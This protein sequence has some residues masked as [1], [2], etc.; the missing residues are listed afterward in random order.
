MSCDKP[1]IA[2]FARPQAVLFDIGMTII[3]PCGDILAHEIGLL[4]PG[5][6]VQGS[7]ALRALALAAE[8]H[9][10]DIGCVGSDSDRVGWVMGHLLGLTPELGIRAWRAASARPD[11]YSLLDPHAVPVLEAL[12]RAGIRT[13][14]VSNALNCIEDELEAFGL[15][16]H[17][18]V[19]IGSGDGYPEKPGTAMFEAALDVLGT[20]ATGAW[21][22]GDGLINDVLGAS[23]AGIAQQILVDRYGIYTKPPCPTISSM[24][25]LLKVVCRL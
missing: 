13:A 6:G 5:C 4:V 10:L 22:V 14:A 19:V 16:P 23:I 15:L 20:R 12:H 21:H 17:F 8:A 9:H 3:H 1:A 11:L 2:N 18:D 7:Q 24:G 25:E